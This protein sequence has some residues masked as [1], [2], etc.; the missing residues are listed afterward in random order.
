MFTL[1][2]AAVTLAMMASVA[3]VAAPTATATGGGA[4][5]S[6]IVVLQPGPSSVRTEASSLAKQYGGRVGFVYG[7]TLRGFSITASSAAAAGIARNPHVAYVEADQV[8]STLESQTTPTGIGRIFAAPAGTPTSATTS[9]PYNPNLGINGADDKRVDVDVAVIDTGIDLNNPDLNVAG[10]INCLNITSGSCVAGGDD[11]HYHGTHVAGTIAALDNGFGVVG[12][13]PGA[14]LWAVKVLDSTGSGTT[15]GV[16]AG[17]DWVAAQ[18]VIEVANLSLGDSKSEAL[19]TSVRNAVAKG[20]SVVVA[21]GN[22]SADAGN[23]S[24]SGEPTAI[25]VSAL[26]DFNG[27]PGGGARLTCTFDV[28]DT[29]AD[30][31]NYGS[32]I[33]MIA[34]GVCIASTNN[35][36]STLRTISGTSMAAPH[37]AGAAALLR[38]MGNDRATTESLLKTSGN[39]DWNGDR[40][41]TK[42]RL[43]DV[44]NTTYFNPVMVGGPANIAPSASFTS[45]CTD[46]AC[47]FDGTPSS[48]AD[49]TIAAYTWAFGD[50]STG[51]GVK[52]THTYANGGTYSVTLTVTDNRGATGSTSAPVTPVT[53]TAPPTQLVFGP[54]ASLQTTTWTAKVNVTGATPGSTVA[55]T[56]NGSSSNGSCTAST[57]GT[58]TISRRKIS[59]SVASVTWTYSAVPSTVVTVFKP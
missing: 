57:S 38:S 27:R 54:S 9:A 48:D 21:A 49:G 33:D 34:P 37:V 13:A 46:L 29:F 43:L 7:H 59:L 15:S 47:S 2:R 1:L 16:I 50:G 24:P 12:V 58:C 42:E 45:T 36:S 52:P 55:G 32:V 18:G 22:I 30:F 14:R 53:P 35:N 17:L 10:S 19:D 25:T 20:V 44:S 11:D 39:L 23:Y 28:D 8:A 3:A 6:Y 56:W 31:S 40:D 5:Q 4:T 41:G 51:S 26:A